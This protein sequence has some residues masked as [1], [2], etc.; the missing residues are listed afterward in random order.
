M[1][2]RILLGLLGSDHMRRATS[3]DRVV[4]LKRADKLSSVTWKSFQLA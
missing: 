3:V 2:L 4:L 1:E